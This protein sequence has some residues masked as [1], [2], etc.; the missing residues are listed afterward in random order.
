MNAKY[1]R[2]PWS[3]TPRFQDKVDV[4]HQSNVIGAASRTICRVTVRDTWLDEQLANARLIAAA[5]ELLAFAQE[6]LTDYQSEDGMDSMK[7]YAAKAHAAI[8]KA[9]G[10]E[11]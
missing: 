2:G 5:P 6:F 3:L 9:T 4:V 8:A 10:S 11:A 1:T 7:R